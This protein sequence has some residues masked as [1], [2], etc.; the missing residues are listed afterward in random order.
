[1]IYLTSIL[2]LNMYVTSNYYTTLQQMIPIHMESVNL[3]VTNSYKRTYG[4]KGYIHI[5]SDTVK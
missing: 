3:P 1:M 5:I 4:I 2:I